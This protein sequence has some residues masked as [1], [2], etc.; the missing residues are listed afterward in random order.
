MWLT[1]EGARIMNP[2]AAYAGNQQRD[3]GPVHNRAAVA[4]VEG[5]QTAWIRGRIGPRLKPEQ[6]QQGEPGTGDQRR[7]HRQITAPGTPRDRG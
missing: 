1:R 2:T 5:E 3:R 7:P 4:T 6:Q